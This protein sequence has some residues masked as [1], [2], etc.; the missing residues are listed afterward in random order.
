MALSN[1]QL[2]E[3]Y[4]QGIA[5]AMGLPNTGNN[6]ILTGN[7]LIANLAAFSQALPPAAKPTVPQAL[8]QVY[9]LANTEIASQ[10]IYSPSMSR[11]FNDYATY[12]DGL[13]PPGQG[14][15]PTQKAQIQLLQRDI[16]AANDVYNADLEKALKAWDT[17]GKA[18]PGKYPTFQSFVNQSSWGQTLNTDNSN[19]SGLNSQLNSLLTEIY[20]ERYLAISTNK[21]VVD[22]IRTAQQGTTVTGPSLMEI[23]TDAGNQIVPKYDP[24]SLSTFSAW[25]DSTIEQHGKAKP[26]K[27]D[28]TESAKRYDFKESSYF[29]QTNWQASFFFFSA[30]GGNTQSGS[31]VNINTASSEF[32]CT[33]LFDAI[34]NV[35]LAA[36][37]WY[38]SSLMFE[39]K[40][41][42][43]L[44]VPNS[45]IVGMYPSIELTMDSE[46]FNAAYSAYNSGSGFGIGTWWASA[47]HSQGSS[48]LNMSTEWNKA[49]NSVMITGSSILPVIVGM[50]VTRIEPNEK[51]A[52]EKLQFSR[53]TLK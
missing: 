33:M 21:Q 40:N 17:Q 49:T 8:A 30:S 41:P 3:V 13:I 36:G 42:K 20:G 15:N 31:Q 18:F 25:V 11:F 7:S 35:Q 44:S 29:S 37:P 14:P 1:E 6:F 23:N 22:N 32:K 50:Q 43:N 46:S 10:G 45:L 34:T 47:S 24:S 51:G 26:I 53:N 48:D 19:I 5:Q 4:A 2:W 52:F 38:D 16:A 39:Y 9:S 12:V 28:F 27:I